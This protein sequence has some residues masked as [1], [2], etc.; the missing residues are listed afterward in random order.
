MKVFGYAR[1]RSIDQDLSIQRAA[2]QA[3][4]CS[5][6]RAETASGT[7]RNGRSELETLMEF[8]QAGDGGENDHAP[9]ARSPSI[10]VGWWR[11]YPGDCA[12]QD[13]LPASLLSARARALTPLSPPLS[14]E[15]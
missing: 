11:S 10:E 7:T 3:A 4:G 1:V 2:L 14:E 12:A 8:L 13:A 5:T 15:S 6:V 9:S